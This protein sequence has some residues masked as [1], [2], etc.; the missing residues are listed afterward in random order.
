MTKEIF[1]GQKLKVTQRWS[2]IEPQ[3]LGS[4]KG[5]ERQDALLNPRLVTLALTDTLSSETL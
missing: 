1:P 4:R 2:I 5:A 3:N